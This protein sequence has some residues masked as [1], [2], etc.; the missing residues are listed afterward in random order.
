[1]SKTRKLNVV[2]DKCYLQGE[3]RTKIAELAS[4]H[5]L[6]MTDAMLYELIKGSDAKRSNWFSKFP[7]VKRPFELIPTPGVLLRYE[8][9]NNKSCGL[10]SS[11]VRPIDHSST[12]LYRDPNYSIPED[13]IALRNVKGGEIDEDVDQVLAFVE[14]IPILFPE[15][16]S[17]HQKDYIALKIVAENKIFND[18]EFVRRGAEFFVAQS[19]YFSSARVANIDRSWL[20]FRWFQ[21]GMLFALELKVKYP[22]GI[23]SV[24]SEKVR[25]KI[26][27]D[28]LD[29]Q[30][31]VLALLEGAFA[32]KEEKLCEWWGKLMP[33]GV[34]YR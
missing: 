6:L 24:M 20:T 22:S 34:L 10:P 17:A 4:A 28:V 16:E 13:L 32:T 12:L 2:I 25:E 1:M 8:L 33:E 7:D 27:H 3:P 23:A 30:Y 15:F 9:K 18:F 14:H 26:R 11:H 31:L 29:A 21:V 19:P 5:G